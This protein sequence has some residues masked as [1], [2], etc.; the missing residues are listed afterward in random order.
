MATFLFPSVRGP[1]HTDPYIY[2]QKL[3]T[4]SWS[5]LGYVGSL[6]GNRKQYRQNTR[7]DDKGTTSTRGDRS[8]RA[9]CV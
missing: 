9:S 3:V 2:V 6:K 4:S 5:I 8:A 7:H 1:Y